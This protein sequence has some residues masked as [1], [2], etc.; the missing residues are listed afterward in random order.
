MQTVIT[1]LR[2]RLELLT[3]LVNGSE[4]L[5]DVHI[6]RSDPEATAWRYDAR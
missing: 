5:E 4:Q 6:L 2:L 1:T 3:D